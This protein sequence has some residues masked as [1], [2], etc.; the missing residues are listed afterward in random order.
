MGVVML[1]LQAAFESYRHREMI[2][3]H[4]PELQL[5]SF[6]EFHY[7]DILKNILASP[8]IGVWV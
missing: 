7:K 3:K 8:T 1:V 2:S 4:N 6:D 5:H